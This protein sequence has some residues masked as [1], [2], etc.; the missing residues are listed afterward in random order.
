MDSLGSK[1]RAELPKGAIVVSNAYELPH[2]WLGPPVDVAFVETGGRAAGLSD[3]SSYL[4]C[5][6]QSNDWYS[7]TT[8][9]AGAS[10][11]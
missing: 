3:T 7:N 9:R 11:D 4:F 10:A 5:Y 6:R 2:T 8:L 1:L